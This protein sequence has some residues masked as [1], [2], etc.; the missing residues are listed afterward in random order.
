MPQIRRRNDK[1]AEA[2]RVLRARRALSISAAAKEAK[3]S[4]DT[5]SALEKGEQTPNVPTLRKLAKSY[6]V[7]FEELLA[8]AVEEPQTVPKGEAP[9]T[10]A[11]QEIQRLHDSG[12]L[13]LVWVTSLQQKRGEVEPVILSEDLARM[14]LMEL[15]SGSNT[16][17]R[18][19]VGTLEEPDGT[20]VGLDI[21]AEWTDA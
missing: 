13:R 18:V 20:S 16:P 21:M 10:S 7:S 2:L 14:L 19:P 9:T 11:R 6:G 1:I 15:A 4:R 17:P 3:V 8:A 12:K 5:L